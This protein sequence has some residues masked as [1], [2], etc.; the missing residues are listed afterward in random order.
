M[1]VECSRS[2]LGKGLAVG[3][4][5]ALAS[6]RASDSGSGEQGV[7]PLATAFMCELAFRPMKEI[8]SMG[9]P[10]EIITVGYEVVPHTSVP[11]KVGL[12]GSPVSG[13]TYLKLKFDFNGVV[14]GGL[15]SSEDEAGVDFDPSQQVVVYLEAIP[16][17][18]IQAPSFNAF[19]PA[20]GGSYNRLEVP[21]RVLTAKSSSDERPARRFLGENAQYARYDGHL[22]IEMG[23]L[24]GLFIHYG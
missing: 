11:Q 10:Q 18:A 9:N 1:I 7:G 16:G 20:S 4:L 6:C 14:H 24:A 8:T 2:R 22:E 3:V 13:G 23:L 17:S 15:A 5:L 19:L 12:G 21:F